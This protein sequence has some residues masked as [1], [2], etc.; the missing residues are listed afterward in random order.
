MQVFPAITV[1][2]VIWCFHVIS[3]NIFKTEEPRGQ[4]SSVLKISYSEADS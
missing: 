2:G 4:F 3:D 1:H